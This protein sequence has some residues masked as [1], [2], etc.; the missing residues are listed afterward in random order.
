M[1]ANSDLS[2]PSLPQL[3]LDLDPHLTAGPNLDGNHLAFDGAAETGKADTRWSGVADLDEE[4]CVCHAVYIPLPGQL[5]RLG[6]QRVARYTPERV[7]I[8]RASVGVMRP[9][10]TSVT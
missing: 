1:L 6:C 4:R 5:L 8:R 10:L 7:T 3:R 9:G 2:P